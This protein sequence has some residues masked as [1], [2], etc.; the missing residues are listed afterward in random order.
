MR[1][2]QPAPST[3]VCL[4]GNCCP[5]TACSYTP[6]ASNGTGENPAMQRSPPWHPALGGEGA[7]EESEKEKKK[8]KSLGKIGERNDTIQLGLKHNV[9][10]PPSST[11][12][13]SRHCQ[14][15]I[16]LLTS[17][18][19]PLCQLSSWDCLHWRQNKGHNTADMHFGLPLG[20]AATE[21]QNPK[22]TLKK[23]IIR[24]CQ[25]YH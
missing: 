22:G 11:Y 25:I 3:A 6:R 12:A 1:P 17:I 14:M 8:T 15:K 24:K 18:L 4:L 2:I 21:E 7:G 16:K 9:I 13:I 23:K 5:C 19:R 10:F 20:Q